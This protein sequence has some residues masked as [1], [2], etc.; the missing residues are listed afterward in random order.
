MELP[1]YIYI[2][3]ICVEVFEKT[4]IFSTICFSDTFDFLSL[5]ISQALLHTDKRKRK[6]RKALSYT[7]FYIIFCFVYFLIVYSF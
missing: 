4:I 7:D 3:Q 2:D 5:L 6:R 1:I